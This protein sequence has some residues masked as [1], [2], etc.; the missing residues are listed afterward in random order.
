MVRPSAHDTT[1]LATRQAEVG[2]VVDVAIRMGVLR[3]R[4]RQAADFAL[5]VAG[6]MGRAHLAAPVWRMLYGI[7]TGEAQ[8]GYR[9]RPPPKTVTRTHN[10]QA[11]SR[12][13]S[14]T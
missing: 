9:A 1:A 13:K 5:L 12:T 11:P 10:R 3:M 2:E 4:P 14:K 6:T 8:D 7:R